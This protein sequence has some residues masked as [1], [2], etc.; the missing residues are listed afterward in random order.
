LAA[1]TEWD[2]GA[3]EIR[4]LQAEWKAVGPVRRN[5]SEAIWQRFRAASDLFF[6]RYKR[7]DEI[8]L[9][10]KQADRE[11]LV[12]E[13]ESLSQTGAES[14]D[15]AP[16]VQGGSEGLL[17]RVRSLRSRWNLTTPVVRQGADPLSA[18]FM[19]ALERV[20]AVYPAAFAGTELDAD[21]NRQKME[22]LCVRVESLTVEHAAQPASGSQALAEMLREALAS[23]TIGGRAGEESKWRSMADEVRQAQAAWSRLGP[24]PGDA[25]RALTERFHRA[26][27][28]FNDLYRRKV[29]PQAQRGRPVGTR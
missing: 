10:S 28:R 14:P 5:K 19:S 16:A 29:P 2:K 21:A 7:R 1:S 12:A 11:G 22:R 4:R 20:M 9:Q 13:L 26:C 23:N 8:D 6:E 18:R 25:A 17:E 27:N 24:V 15:A 3:A